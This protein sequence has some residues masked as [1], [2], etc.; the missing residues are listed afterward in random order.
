MTTT[1]P[2]ETH[3]QIAAYVAEVARRLPAAQRA[4]VREELRATLLDSVEDRLAGSPD[5]TRIDEVVQEV[6]AGLGDPALLARAYA[7]EGR[8]LIGPAYFD[9]WSTL[10]RSLLATVVPIVAAVTFVLDLWAEDSTLLGAVGSTVWMALTLSLHLAFWVTLVFWILERTGSPAPRDERRAW[11]P[12]DLP[13]APRRRT[14]GAAELVWGVGVAVVAITWLLW[15]QHRPW[16]A[17]AS[18]EDVPILD[19][20]LWPGWLGGLIGLFA[21]AAVVEV[22]KYAA[23]TWTL[24]VTVLSVLTDLALAAYVLAM[25]AGRGLV[26]PDLLARASDPPAIDE[27]VRR[28]VAAGVVLVAAMSIVDAIRSHLRDRAAVES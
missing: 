21:V 27:N 3:P 16:I 23:A 25:V 13:A 2:P 14:L 10:L 20:A 4:D 6:L 28:I 7:P 24:P 19:P 18:G 1:S 26:N 11:T 22:A 17:G 9:D 5:P 15:Q 8:H 12:D